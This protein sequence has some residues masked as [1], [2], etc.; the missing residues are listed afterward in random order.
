MG[1]TCSSVHITPTGT[2][3]DAIEGIVRAYPI[4]GVGL[5]VGLEQYPEQWRELLN[6]VPD[7]G[8]GNRSNATVRAT[9]FGVAVRRATLHASECPSPTV[10]VH[11]SC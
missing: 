8:Y 1:N 11:Q 3:P 4:A 2:T 6:P 10:L 7:G 9:R 5:Q